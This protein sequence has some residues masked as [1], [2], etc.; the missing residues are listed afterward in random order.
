MGLDSW[1]FTRIIFDWVSPLFMWFFSIVAV[2]LED[3]V[4]FGQCA[5]H[6]AVGNPSKEDSGMHFGDTR[7]ADEGFPPWFCTR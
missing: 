5:P 1:D 7:V 6:C 2:P 3:D 4:F